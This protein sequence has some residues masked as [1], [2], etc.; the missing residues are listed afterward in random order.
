MHISIISACYKV[1]SILFFGH[2]HI[3]EYFGNN[4]G[5]GFYPAR[6]FNCYSFVQYD[7]IRLQIMGELDEY[8]EVKKKITE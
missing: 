5:L 6:L 2:R 8:V 1:G 4:Y 3:L 7:Q